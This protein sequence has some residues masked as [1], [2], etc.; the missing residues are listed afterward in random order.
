MRTS[1]ASSC[2]SRRALP[3][4][5]HRRAA[6]LVIDTLFWLSFVADIF[7]GCYWATSGFAALLVK[8][9]VLPLN[10]VRVVVLLLSGLITPVVIRG[11]V[12]LVRRRG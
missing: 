4:A 6:D 7:A 9:R 8:L 12:L 3:R 5:R 2:P 1:G 10:S 11:M